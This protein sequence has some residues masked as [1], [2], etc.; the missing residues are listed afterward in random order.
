MCVGLINCAYIL[1]LYSYS[2]MCVEPIF[3]AYSY[4][5]MWF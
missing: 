2:F 4:N 3:S 1:G 5:V